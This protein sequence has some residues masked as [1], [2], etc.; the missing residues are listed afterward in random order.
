MLSP[1]ATAIESEKNGIPR[2]ALSE[3]SM[4]STT[5][6]QRPSPTSPTS[7]DTIVAS[8]PSKR[9]RI[10]RSAAASIAVVSSP[11]SPCASTGSRSARDGSSASTPRTSSAAPRHRASQSVKRVEEQAARELGKEIGRLLRQHLAAPR[12]REDVLDP[13]RP[14][15]E[16]TLGVA[17]I[18]GRLRLLAARRVRDA[19]EREP[20]DDLDVEPV[21]FDELIPAAAVENDPGQLASRPFDLVALHVVDAACDPV[22]REDRQAF[23]ARRHEHVHH[24]AA[25]VAP[26]LRVERERRLVPMMP[27]RDQELIGNVGHGVYAPEPFAVDRQVWLARR[28]LD[29]VAVVEEEDRFELRASRSQEAKASLLR[30]GV[31]AFVRQDDP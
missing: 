13:R 11:P 18:D 27:V 25:R 20:I 1:S 8:S 9:A 12:V 5:T 3:P 14:Q 19:F 23:L 7:S 31:R 6:R 16:R 21:A 28:Q 15:Q 26:V 2:F 17:A 29:L 4:G 30:P 10:T 24:P 22:C